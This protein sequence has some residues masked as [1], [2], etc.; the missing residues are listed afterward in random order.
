MIRSPST[1]SRVKHCGC[2]L[3]GEKS[4]DKHARP[5][6]A[7][8]Q[9]AAVEAQIQVKAADTIILS[10]R[11]NHKDNGRKRSTGLRQM[12]QKEDQGS[13]LALCSTLY[14]H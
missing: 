7:G 1:R 6:C 14:W 11:L 10:S 5:L 4:P 8:A 9:V 2:H 12:P 13:L 3:H